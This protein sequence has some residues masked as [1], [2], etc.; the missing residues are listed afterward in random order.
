MVGPVGQA[1][2]QTIQAAINA[3]NAAGGGIV[4]IQP[5]TY[6]ENIN[7]PDKVHL[8]GSVFMQ[9][10]SS[11]YP[12][13]IHGTLT[14][15]TSANPQSSYN[16]FFY[17]FFNP[18]TGDV[19]TFNTSGLFQSV[20]MFYG[21]TLQVNQAT[22]AVLS[23]DGFPTVYLDLCQCTSTISNGDLFALRGGARFNYVFARDTTFSTNESSYITPTAGSD[24]QY[25]L[26]NCIW[27]AMV[28]VSSSAGTYFL[29]QTK[30]CTFDWD[31]LGG[32]QP[33]INYGGT[34]G[35]FISQNGIVQNVPGALTSSTSVASNSFFNIYDTTFNGTYILSSN[36]KEKIYNCTFEG[37]SSPAIT[38][39]SAQ[40]VTI[41][42][43]AINTSANPAIAGAGAGTLTLGGLTFVNGK[44]LAGTLT[45]AGDTGFLPTTMSNG[46]LLI[47]STGAV[48]AVANLTST[49]AT[50]TI[51]NGAGT[52]NLETAGGHAP[53]EQFLPDSGTSPVV[54][55]GSGQVTMAG[56]G[57][58]TTVGGTNTLTTELT[59]L[60][61]HAV[62]VGAG[63]TTITKVGPSATTGAPLISGGAAADPL[64][65]TTVVINDATE[66]TTL[67]GTTVNVQ[68]QIICKNTTTSGTGQGSNIIATAHSS[69][70]VAD[71]G[72]FSSGQWDPNAGAGNYWCFGMTSTSSSYVNAYNI[73]YN[74]SGGTPSP[75]GGTV[76]MSLG[77][78]GLVTV[79][80]GDVHVVRSLNTGGPQISLSNTSVVVGATARITIATAA[81]GTTSDAYT[82]LVSG[83]GSGSAWEYGCLGTNKNFII[84]SGP[85]N[86][87]PYMDGT[88]RFAIAQTGAIT[89]NS[90][91]TFPTADGTAGQV[92]TTNG[93]GTVTWST[94][95]V[96]TW[97]DTSGVFTASRNSA[98]FLTAASTATLPA[99]PVQGDTV[100]FVCDTTGS[101]VIT[102]NAGQSIRIANQLSSVAGTAT[103]SARGDTLS[104]VYRAATTT[105]FAFDAP[106]GGW[107]TA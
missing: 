83:S 78:T 95:G 2:Y 57:S 102:A 28:D 70:S 106:N 40:N 60:T 82:L 90:A 46:Q 76:M 65:S 67:T 98:Y 8:I 27:N 13:I 37:G 20:A 100:D 24:I 63:T 36:C 99:A 87:H 88:T 17:L 103:N 7:V 105:W 53:I 43:S 21:C 85:D 68:P 25:V 69:G 3:A 89:F 54:P 81:D 38:M 47:G 5:G 26:N 23:T 51:T 33:L 6:T 96:G 77:T 22:K 94:S 9:D 14:V 72:Y 10:Y 42:D 107:T 19:F 16:N 64:F 80:T 71:V 84:Q 34:E 93:A 75:E 73:S 101:C 55:N 50:I 4:Y 58:I 35:A 66:T 61:N 32:T 92:L 45:L 48:P 74:G 31:G 15:D 52:I 104:L 44:N 56:S 12:V 97:T 86:T 79:P 18:P 30:N 62:L 39:S 49:G 11:G 91:F 41:S 1:G 59:G 29:L